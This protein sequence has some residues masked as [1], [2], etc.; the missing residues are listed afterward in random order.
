MIVFSL[1][2]TFFL[3]LLS[4]LP[5][6]FLDWGVGKLMD[7]LIE[8][9]LNHE[10]P[11]LL[12]L[13]PP[14]CGEQRF[15]LAQ[16]RLL[17]STAFGSYFAGLLE[18]E[19]GYV[20]IDAQIHLPILQTLEDL[21]PLQKMFWAFNNPQGPH[22]M[23]LVGQGGMGK[24]TLAAK[25]IRCLHE[26][27][28]FDMILGDSAKTQYVD[29]STGQITQLKPAFYNASSFYKRLC[30]QLGL[31]PLTGGQASQAI[32]DRLLGN[33]VLIV[34]DNLD[35]VE[36]GTELLTSLRHLTSRDVRVIV[37]TR[38]TVGL[39]HLSIDYLLVNLALLKDVMDVSRFLRWH[40]EQYQDQHTDLNNLIKDINNTRRI[41]WL[42]EKTG[43]NPLLLQLVWSDAASHSW[44]YVEN[45]PEL[46]GEELQN[47]LFELKWDELRN[48]AE[49]GLIAREL[50]KWVAEKQNY[51][52]RVD[53]KRILN[54]ITERE[55]TGILSQSLNLLY[56]RFLL[57]NQDPQ[58]GN[59]TV[60]PSLA[61][62]L[63]RQK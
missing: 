20:H 57:I 46:F 3:W 51:G 10:A 27:N 22:L 15:D 35:T 63:Q 29:P 26:N 59:Y 5:D 25:V 36:K 6:A 24:S 39:K 18:R 41:K 4:R 49:P 58:R 61:A 34:V 19:K 44:S 52:D 14:T 48:L 60:V 42:T 50:L 43:G 21:S 17:V 23:I 38:E 56:E 45:L 37:T 40:T 54:W 32:Q 13:F 8:I 16:Q 11:K 28:T 47:Y 12:E 2:S 30:S 31:P 55:K 9:K 1:I 53:S 7:L 33:R 62:F